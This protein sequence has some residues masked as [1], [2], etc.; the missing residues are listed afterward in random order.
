MKQIITLTLLFLFSVNLRA[1]DTTEDSDNAKIKFRLI[2][3]VNVGGTAPLPLPNTV[4]EIKNY[5]ISFNPA[6]GIEGVYAFNKKWSMGANPRIEYKGMKVKNRVMYMH[7]I[8][9]VEDGTDVSYFEGAFSGINYTETRNAYLSIPLFVQF[10]PRE[11]WHYRLGGYL[12]FL[13]KSKFSGYVSDGYIR[14][15]GS[16]GEKVEVSLASFNFSDN[17]R[18]FDCGLNAGVNRNIGNHWSVDL[19]LQWGLLSVFPSSFTGVTFP[20]YNI[21]GQ[22]GV[23]YRL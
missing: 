15:G 23:G 2:L 6:I 16:L 7:T 9:E 21:F 20:M 12:A 17:I 18:K 11:Q 14:N 19:N 8:I 22:F 1:Q 3:G 4:R 13:L 5:N 10:T